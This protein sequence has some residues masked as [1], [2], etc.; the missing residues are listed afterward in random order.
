MYAARGNHPH[1]CN[2][3]LLRDADV[4][5]TNLNDDT[6]FSLAVNNKSL[7]GNVLDIDRFKHSDHNVLFCSSSS[8]R[9]LFI[10][11][12]GLMTFFSPN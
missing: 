1:C 12:V 8:H 2:E 10:D 7:L 9:E 3:L 11:S 5:M 6:A 4:T